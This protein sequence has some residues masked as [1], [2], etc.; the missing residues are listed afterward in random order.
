MGDNITPELLLEYRKYNMTYPVELTNYIDDKKKIK[1]M[2]LF[3]KRD[4]QSKSTWS[5]KTKLSHT[6]NEKLYADINDLLNK[7]NKKNFDLICENIT[8]SNIVCREHMIELVKR[9]MEEAMR[10]HLFIN[11]YAQACN[12]L[13]PYYIT[14]G[15]EKVHFRDVLLSKCQ[16]TFELYAKNNNDIDKKDLIGMIKFIGELYNVNVLIT[17]VIFMCFV[18]LYT[19]VMNKKQHSV[20]AICTLMTIVGKDFYQKDQIKA[21]SCYLKIEELLQN[22]NIVSKEKFMIMDLKELKEKENW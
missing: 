9:I 22:G 8:K 21:K 11:I 1:D 14:E 20:E 2:E 18:T 13:M 5:L 16:E 7:L 12:I 6:E 4:F 19:N 10:N 3:W 17:S 15:N